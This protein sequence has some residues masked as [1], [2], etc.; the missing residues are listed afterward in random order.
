MSARFAQT[1]LDAEV[2]RTTEAAVLVRLE[3]GEEKWIPRSVCL[4][5][6]ALDVGDSEVIVADWWIEKEGLQ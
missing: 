4:E 6:D 1:T 3:S 2:T 5:G